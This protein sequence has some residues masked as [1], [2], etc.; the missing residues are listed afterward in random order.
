MSI[1]FCAM[2]FSFAPSVDCLTEKA[3]RLTLPFVTNEDK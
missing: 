1:T 2:S 3:K